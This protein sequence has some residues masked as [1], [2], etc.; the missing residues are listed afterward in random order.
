MMREM[1]SLHNNLIEISILLNFSSKII[2]CCFCDDF[3][4][5]VNN[6][7]WKF[8]TNFLLLSSGFLISSR[9]IFMWSLNISFENWNQK[10]Y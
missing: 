4:F 9:K 10:Y 8:I 7:S 1:N 6:F 3:F 2:Q 5:R